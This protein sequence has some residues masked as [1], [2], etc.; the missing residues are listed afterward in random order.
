MT[1]KKKSFEKP[2]ETGH[3]GLNLEAPLERAEAVVHFRLTTG[4]DFLGECLTGSAW[5]LTRPSHSSAMPEWMATT[6][7]NAL[8]SMNTRLM[9]S[10]VSTGRF[11]V[12]WS[13]SQPRV[14]DK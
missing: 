4:H 2:W 1:Q 3:S 8:D 13:K 7:S 5:L 10:S 6:C 14:L 11:D 12:Q 9:T